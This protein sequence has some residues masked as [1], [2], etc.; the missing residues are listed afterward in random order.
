MNALSLNSLLTY[1]QSLPL[2][3]S[4]KEWL[5]DH[6]VEP[7]NRSTDEEG[8]KILEKDFGA[9]ACD[10]EEYSTEQFIEELNAMCAGKDFVET[11]Q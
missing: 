4:N 6:L 3:K 8:L 5:A 7:V 1:I 2:T 9:W 11:L 10:E